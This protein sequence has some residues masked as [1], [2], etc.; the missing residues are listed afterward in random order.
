MPREGSFGGV[1]QQ[2]EGIAF[3]CQVASERQQ[4]KEDEEGGLLRDRLF[5][6]I[7]FRLRRRPSLQNAMSARSLVRFPY[8]TPAFPNALLY[9]ASH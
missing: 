8:A 6:T 1:R 5:I 2:N 4:E 7:Y 3:T 9:F